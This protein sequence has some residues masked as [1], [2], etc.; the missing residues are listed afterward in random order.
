MQNKFDDIRPYNLSEIPPAMQRI[1]DSEYFDLLSNYIFP[2]RDTEEIRE[3]VRNIRTTDE[4]QQQVMYYANEQFTTR[5]ISKFTYGGLDAL[6]PGKNYLFI[7]NH[8]DIMLDSSLLQY[9]LHANGFRT[10]E[11]TFGSNLMHP[12]LVVDI[13]KANKM[14]KVIRSSNIREF[15]K[16]SM[17]LSDYIRYT[18]TRKGSSIWIAQRNGRTKDGNDLTDQGIIKMFCMS[19]RTDDMAEAL[20][21]L[22]IIPIAIS[23]QIESCDIL[24]TRELYLS[25]N[26]QKYVKQPGEDLN[27]ILTGIRQPKGCVNIH[28]C[29]PLALDELAEVDYKS[30]N[31]FYKTIASIIDK[32]IYKHYKLYNNNYIAHDLR[33]GRAAYAHY[34]TPEE[35]EAFVARYRYMLEQIEGDKDTLTSIFLGIYAIP[36]DNAKNP[37]NQ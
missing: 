6:D 33:S 9:I 27:S 8:R 4:F 16:N 30:P 11:I 23:Y 26:G 18:L 3:M 13:G 19:S 1:A 7:S 35:K 24:K 36:V 12:Q 37:D 28:I 21:E 14:F 2:G 22:N 32:R 17:H 31:E 25:R 29:E 15:I 20:D 10:T 34:Y 5:S